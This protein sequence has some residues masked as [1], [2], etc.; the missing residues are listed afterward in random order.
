MKKTITA[1]SIVALSLLMATTANADFPKDSHVVSKGN[2]YRV[3]D[4]DTYVVNL[5][6][7]KY[8][9]MKSY[10]KGDDRKYFND[11]HNSIRIRL[12]NTD[13]A[14]SVHKDKRKN[15]ERG[16]NISS[17]V[18]NILEKKDVKVACYDFGKYH[19]VICNVAFPNKGNM[20]DMGGYLMSNGL[21]NYVTYFGKSPYY[22]EQYKKLSKR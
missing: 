22:H 20:E 17:H 13:T 8:R 6:K 16:K 7:S 1:V 5:P 2:V 15:T 4:G 21:S 3:I 9:E 14:E 12:A 10:A 19:R 18:T 11:R